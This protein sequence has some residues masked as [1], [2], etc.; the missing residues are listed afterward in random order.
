MIPGR[1][2]SGPPFTE[3]DIVNEKTVSAIHHRK[4]GKLSDKWESYLRY[5]DALFLPRQDRD[6]SL[7]EIGVQNGGSL[8]TWAEYFANAK[9]IV[10]C[11]VD[12]RCGSLT[13]DDERISVVI[14]DV[15]E[16]ATF[17][18]IQSLSQ[19]FDIIIDD[20]SHMPKDI[21]KAFVDYFPIVKPGG[22]FIIE[23]CCT[24]YW[25]QYDG[26]LLS[27]TTPYAL[28]KKLIDVLNFEFWQNEC[29]IETYLRSFFPKK[30]T[31]EFI[32][33]GWIESIEFRNSV[34]T[35]TKAASP[36][37]QKLGD[38]TVTGRSR[39]I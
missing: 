28:F 3:R 32:L 33:Q 34:I 25:D 15:R 27:E 30:S 14:G 20:G 9:K 8:E 2:A 23:D 7:L 39:I 22:T 13:Y 10:G 1:G 35:V 12:P 4:S 16:A 26:G 11:D 18:K 5:Y 29:S 36:T 24:L 6:I 38:R 37:H 31:P 19:T 21:I 17:Q